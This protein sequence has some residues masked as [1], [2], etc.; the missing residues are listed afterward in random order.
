MALEALTEGDWI[1]FAYNA[2]PKCPHCGHDHDVNDCDW[3][4][5]YEEG[6]HEVECVK[7]D[8]PFTVSTY[9]QHSYSTDQQEQS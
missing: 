5:L 3:N 1:D 6:E 2:G 7:C 4:H 9:V 8:A